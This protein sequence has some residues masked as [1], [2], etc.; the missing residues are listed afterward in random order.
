MSNEYDKD[1]K[2][3]AKLIHTSLPPQ[4]NKDLSLYIIKEV[5]RLALDY[6]LKHISKPNVIIM[7]AVFYNFLCNAYGEFGEK[8]KIRQIY[9]M[10]I[11]A[12]WGEVPMQVYEEVEI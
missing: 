8:I 10:K 4:I 11:I 12:V 3:L 7:P 6:Q 2:A 1:L 9:G 5:K